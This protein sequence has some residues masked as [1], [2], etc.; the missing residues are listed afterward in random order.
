[1]GS[2]PR[3]SHDNLGHGKFLVSPRCEP[4]DRGPGG[5]S[6]LIP[7]ILTELALDFS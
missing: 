4:P 5:I 6:P 2:A 1:M 3:A 7:H